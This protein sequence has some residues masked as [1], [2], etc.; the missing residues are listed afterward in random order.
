MF[1]PAD[2][3]IGG[4]FVDTAGN[5]GPPNHGYWY[6]I[7]TLGGESEDSTPYQCQ[8][9]LPELGVNNVTIAGQ[10]SNGP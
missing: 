3:I 9:V 4:V 7:H 6:W 2:G 10:P 8:S 1:D 5:F